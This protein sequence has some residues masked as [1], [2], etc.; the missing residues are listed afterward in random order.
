MGLPGGK[1]PW[2]NRWPT[3]HD[4]VAGPV[5]DGKRGLERAK[6]AALKGALRQEIPNKRALLL[7]CSNLRD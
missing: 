6:A 3:S 2:E 4:S 1:G 7:L 5:L